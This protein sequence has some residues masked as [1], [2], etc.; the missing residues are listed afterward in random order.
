MTLHIESCSN[1]SL[2]FLESQSLKFVNIVMQKNL[3][4]ITIFMFI[5]WFSILLMKFITNKYR[6]SK[7]SWLNLTQTA[8]TQN[9]IINNFNDQ[10]KCCMI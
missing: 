9:Q 5:S 1:L 7:N 8:T 3:N 2:I 10:C 4:R 6:S